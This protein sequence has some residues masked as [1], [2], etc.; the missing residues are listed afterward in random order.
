[1]TDE[2][3]YWC[4][5]I[6]FKG[7]D[8]RYISRDS[9]IEY[10][11]RLYDQG[12]SA[13]KINQAINAIKYFK[14]KVLGQ[15]RQTYFLKRPR[16]SK[17]IPTILSPEQMQ[18]VINAPKNLKHHTILFTI[19]DNGIRIGE[20]INLRLAD[21]RTRCKNPYIII[22]AAKH[23]GD[24]VLYLSPQCLEKL[25]T[26]YRKFKPKTYLFEGATT[27]QPIS[28]T[29][30]T[31]VLNKAVTMSRVTEHLRV[32]DLRHNF[33]THCLLAGTSIYDLSRQLGHK[34]VETTQK[35]YVHLLPNQI[36]I[37]RPASVKPG[38]PVA[39]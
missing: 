5:Q 7:E 26:Y 1:M 39:A 14:E 4:G 2:V 30:I 19:Y 12:Y 32:H 29:T 13:S 10:L 35:Y 33:A 17:F 36:K 31:K 24:R 3:I 23:N 16:R 18:T 20:L 8:Y 28:K 11:A 34:K 15:K 37:H 22:R 38:Q 6:Y 25:Q 21:V 9:I 27:G